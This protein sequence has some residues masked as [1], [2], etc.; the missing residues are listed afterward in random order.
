[1]LIE[2]DGFIRQN[3]LVQNIKSSVFKYL[4]KEVF[5]ISN[6]FFLNFFIFF[7]NIIF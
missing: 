3:F 1:M 2:K 6:L 5:F 4:L 7:L